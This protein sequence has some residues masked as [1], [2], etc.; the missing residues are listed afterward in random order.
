M[1]PTVGKMVDRQPL[2]TIGIPTYN[3]AARL[4]RAIDSALAQDYEQIELVVSDNAS[5]DETQAVCLAASA[6][7]HR[8]RYLRQP[9]NR[10]MTANLNEVLDQAR[11]EFFMWLADDDWLDPDYISRCTQVLLHDSEYAIACGSVKHCADN[12]TV[13]M[14]GDC[15]DLP[16]DSG[17]ERVLEYFRQ[18]R[19][20]GTFYGVMR[21][22]RLLQ[23]HLRNTLAGDWLLSVAIIFTGKVKI[24]PETCL[25]RSDGGASASME[26]VLSSVGVP[27]IFAK[28][29]NLFYLKIAISVFNQILLVSPS[30]K[31]IGVLKRLSLAGSAFRIIQQRFMPFRLPFR[32]PLRK[33][34]NQL[35]NK[36]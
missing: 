9:I 30:F 12:G 6:A 26:A 27:L 11:G 8:I 22:E 10:G 28:S 25:Y 35:R 1:V 32:K 14:D 23:E 15:I 4:K 33:V 13:V 19:Y 34:L 20:D 16:Q 7:D 3:R 18:I 24:I 29:E 36:V 17:N 5:T 21:R 31:S 2:I